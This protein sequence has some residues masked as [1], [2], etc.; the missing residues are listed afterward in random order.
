MPGSQQRCVKFGLIWTGA[1][2]PG[3]A[4]GSSPVST[5]RVRGRGGGRQGGREGRGGMGSELRQTQ[6]RLVLC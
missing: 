2:P 3:S 1:W 5:E 4:L 6:G